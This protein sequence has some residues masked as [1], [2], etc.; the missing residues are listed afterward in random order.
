MTTSKQIV[1]VRRRDDVDEPEFAR[2]LIDYGS[3]VAEH[4]EGVVKVAINVVQTDQRLFEIIGLRIRPIEWHG[5]VHT[6]FESSHPTTQ[7]RRYPH[8]ERALADHLLAIAS[9]STGWWVDENN[10]WPYDRDWPDGVA[11]PGIKQMSLVARRPD[12]TFDEF[13][14]R[15]RNHVN[16][17][18]LHHIGCWQYVQNFVAEPVGVRP[19]PVIDGIS[20]LWFRSIDDM[21]ERFYTA[22]GSPEAVRDD[23][24]GFIDF[25][26]TRSYLTVETIVFSR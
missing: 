26:N 7:A 13:V 8:S 25:A 9:E 23:T 6:W 15:Y 3:L 1:L 18:K 19:S 24:S 22:P 16:I 11:T 20:E 17:A 2:Q 4:H 14:T 10:A 21:V 5:L 12:I